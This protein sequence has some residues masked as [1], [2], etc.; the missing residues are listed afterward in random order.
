M[1][2]SRWH[3][4]ASF[5]SG[6]RSKWVVLAAWLVLMFVAGSLASKLNSVQSNATE[7]WLPSNA[8]STRALSVAEEHFAAKDITSA[9]VVYARSSGLTDADHAKIEADQRSVASLSPEQVPPATYSTDGK[10]ALITVGVTTSSSDNSVLGDAVDQIQRTVRANAPPGLEIGITGQAGNITDYIRIFSGLDSTLLSIAVLIVAVMLLVTYRSLVLWLVPLITVMA[11]VQ[12]ASAAVYLLAK[13]GGVLVNGQNA[14]VL[15]V[16]VLGVGTDYALLLISRYREELRRHEDRHAAMAAALS[17]CMSA[18]VASAATVVVATLCLLFGTMNSTRGLGPVAAVSV[19]VAFLAMVSLLPAFLVSLGR[20]VFWPVKPRYGTA[21]ASRTSVWGR[22]ARFVGAR[23]RPVWISTA[24]VLIAL[25]FGT[26][27]LH[28]GQTQADQ[29]TKRTDSVVGQQLLAEHFAAGSSAPVDVFTR[30]DNANAALAAVRSVPGVSD[31]TITGT[32]DGWTHLTAVMTAQPDTAAARQTVRDVRSAVA[33]VPGEVLVGGKSA[34]ALDTAEAQAREERILI[35]IILIVVFIMLIVLLRSIVA[36]LVLLASTVVSFGAAVGTAGLLFK[37]LG[38]PRIDRGL[39]VFGFLFLVA[40]GVDYTVFLMT[41]V[42]EEVQV[43]GHHTGVL[44]GLR[45]TGGVITSAG[46][47]LAASFFVLAALP[48]V[49]SLQ[50]GLLIGVGVLLDTFLVRSLLVPGLSLHVGPRLWWPNRRT[51][52][53]TPAAE[54]RRE[55]T[56][57]G[58]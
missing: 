14:T 52:P 21:E 20:W 18:I 15:Y 56:L 31:V 26:L 33:N 10:A 55:A 37:A 44:E 35:P 13:A 34:V 3:R 2:N 43:H 42:R 12:V 9:V 38:Y 17:R 11:A 8:Q 4:Y 58:V 54:P 29:F 47:I 40:L 51:V 24:L 50:Q 27:A 23:P 28:S 57:A 6:R 19:T 36:P 49:N 30:S 22:V 7:T 41:R 53:S 25:S 46:L 16:L 48:V 45:I 5:V 1:T 39:I 32:A